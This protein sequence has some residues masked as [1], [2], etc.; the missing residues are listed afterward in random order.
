[1]LLNAGFSKIVS[2]SMCRSPPL[3]GNGDDLVDPAYA[4]GVDPGSP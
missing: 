3:A 1:V 2:S 4:G